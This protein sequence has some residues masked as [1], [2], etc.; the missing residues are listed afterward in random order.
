MS[1]TDYATIIAYREDAVRC[2]RMLCEKTA[3]IVATITAERDAALAEVERLK[4]QIVGHEVDAAYDAMVF[5]AQSVPREIGP[6]DRAE[7]RAEAVKAYFVD[8]MHGSFDPEAWDRVVRAVLSTAT[9]LGVLFAQ[10]VQRVELTEDEHENFM[11][12]LSRSFREPTGWRKYGRAAIEHLNAILAARPAG[13]SK[14]SCETAA[15]PVCEESVQPD[16]VTVEI[17]GGAPEKCD[18]SPDAGNMV[19]PAPFDEGKKLWVIAYMAAIEGSPWTPGI[20][21]KDMRR[22]ALAVAAHIRATEVEPLK[23]RVAEL[24]AEVDR[25][26]YPDMLGWN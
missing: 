23:Q 9:R 12:F 25:L 8:D 20:V 3:G 24:E 6:L 11:T 22:A 26:R 15:C 19:P 1:E 14:A 10:P 2:A 18:H 13:E 21:G 16:S 7:F 4:E 5:G 17:A